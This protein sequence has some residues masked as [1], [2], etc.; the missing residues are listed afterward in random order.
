MFLKRKVEVLIG[1]RSTALKIKFLQTKLNNG[2]SIDKSWPVHFLYPECDGGLVSQE[3]GRKHACLQHLAQGEP[4]CRET[5]SGQGGSLK[6]IQCGTSFKFCLCPQPSDRH[7]L[8][9]L[10]TSVN[11]IH[12]TTSIIDCLQ[13]LP[14]PN[15]AL[16][17]NEGKT[18]GEKGLFYSLHRLTP[19]I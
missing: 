6:R 18:F 10:S 5:R 4:L 17:F 13:L 11:A 15:K 3:E 7:S 9:I 12:H 2:R 8:R 16:C 19:N 1:K 14:T